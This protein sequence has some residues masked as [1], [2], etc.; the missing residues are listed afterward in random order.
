MLAP[1]G[2]IMVVL[3]PADASSKHISEQEIINALNSIEGN[4]HI[5]VLFS[6]N[7]H[8][9]AARLEGE[10]DFLALIPGKGMVVIE[11]KAPEGVELKD[12][13][14][15]LKGVPDEKKDPFKQVDQAREEVLDFL[16][17]RIGL[18]PAARAVWLTSIDASQLRQFTGGIGILPFE[19]RSRN[20]LKNPLATLHEIIDGYNLENDGKSIHRPK[21]LF[22]EDEVQRA[23]DFLQNDFSAD[24]KR[25]DL[26]EMRQA[27]LERLED[28]QLADLEGFRRNKH[29]YIYGAAGTGKSF[30]LTQIA[31]RAYE[32]DQRVLLTCWNQMMAEDLSNKWQAVYPEMVITDLGSLMAE[33]AGVDLKSGNGDA[34]YTDELPKLALSAL[35]KDP[36]GYDFDLIAVDEYQDIA[37]NPIFLQFLEKLGKGQSWSKTRVVLAGDKYQ[38]ILGAGKF[39]DNPLSLAE[40]LIPDFSVQKLTKNFRNAKGIV[41]A[42]EK[43]TDKKVTYSKTLI[44]S[45]KGEVELVEMDTKTAPRKLRDIILALQTKYYNHQIRVLSPERTDHSMPNFILKLPDDPLRPEIAEL[46]ALLKNAETGT[47]VIPWRSIYRY[48]GLESDVVVITDATQ[49]LWESLEA[50]GK[51]LLALLYVGVSRAHHKVVILCDHFVAEKLRALN[52]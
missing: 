44:T 9:S 33:I 35:E 29:I 18:Y 4:D 45:S 28:E 12:R 13:K 46:K 3:H 34:W 2:V 27:E 24:A 38:Q 14:M 36:D 8:H 20:D 48:K 10:I 1:K 7:I 25:E 51:S 26:F 32:K 30:M 21:E 41:R 37:A 47:G 17:K 19:L 52:L 15:F 22:T 23:I 5:H 39:E 11:A 49:A 31:F 16:S 42:L 6:L 43:L 50:E 40:E